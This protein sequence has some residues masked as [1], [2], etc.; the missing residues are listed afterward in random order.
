MY[1]SCK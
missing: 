1:M